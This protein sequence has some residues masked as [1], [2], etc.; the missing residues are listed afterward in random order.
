MRKNCDLK[1]RQEKIVTQRDTIYVEYLTFKKTK[2]VKS[3]HCQV[4]K[5]SS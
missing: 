5:R 2:I 1:R 4:A 3:L